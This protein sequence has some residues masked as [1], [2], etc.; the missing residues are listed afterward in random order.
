MKLLAKKGSTAL[1][2]AL[3][4]KVIT[5]IYPTLMVGGQEVRQ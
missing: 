4:K 3:I 2:E 5:L 1:K